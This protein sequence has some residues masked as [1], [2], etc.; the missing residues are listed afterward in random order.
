MHEQTSGR[1]N[2]QKVLWGFLL[3]SGFMIAEVIGILSDPAL[4]ADA[5]HMFTDAASLGLA[6]FAFRISHKPADQ[7]RTFGYYR[8]QVLAAFVNGVSLAAIVIWILVEA[9][10]RLFHPVEVM[11][12][13]ML[14]IAVLGLLINIAVFLI[15]H[16][17]ERNNLNIRGALLHVLGDLL[18]SAVAI[19]AALVI[20][21]TGW[22]PI[23]PILSLLVA[24]LILRSAWFLIRESG[25]ILLEG[26]PENLNLSDVR[27]SL[28]NN[29]RE[30]DE[31][32]HI[33]AWSLN[34][35]K[36]LISFHVNVVEG[37]NND[38]IL[39]KVN[40]H[41]HQEFGI[42]HITVQVEHKKCTREQ[43]GENH[44]C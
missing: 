9:V 12:N 13:T 34:Q 41:I 2:E 1:N 32:H 15:L 38:E 16:S 33:H 6:W 42:E 27:L 7:L 26:T 5:G 30:I 11:G 17:G 40:H 36:P 22:N 25:H 4:L 14:L 29:V 37:V 35:E 18:G 44:Q 39:N 21:A 43:A 19:V 8:F 3:T 10:R 23:D 28:M 20:L 24:L 31:V